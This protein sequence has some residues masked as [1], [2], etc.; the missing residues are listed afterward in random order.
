MKQRKIEDNEAK[1]DNEA[2]EANKNQRKKTEI[3]N[4]QEQKVLHIGSR[5]WD[6]GTE[7]TSW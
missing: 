4:Q 7:E 2:M 1:E 5:T 6:F 3:Q